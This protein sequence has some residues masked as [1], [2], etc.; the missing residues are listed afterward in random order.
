MSIQV[1]TYNLTRIVGGVSGEAVLPALNAPIDDIELALNSLSSRIGNM[2]NKSAIIRQYVPIAEGVTPGMLVYYDTELSRFAPA[3]AK[4]MA[5]PGS[6]GQSIEH[7]SSRVEG[8]IISIDSS[9]VTG[10]MLTGGA[11]ESAAVAQACLGSAAVAGTYYLSPTTAGKAVLDPGQHLRQAVLS[12]YGDG[13]LNLNMFYMAHDNHFHSSAVLTG[14]WLPVTAMED[15]SITIPTGATF[16]Y[17][18]V[19]DPNLA[20]VGELSDETTLVVHNGVIITPGTSFVISQGYLWSKELLIPASGEVTIFNHF[21]YAYNSPVVRSVTS[22]PGSSVTIKNKNGRVTIKPSD[23]ISGAVANSALAVSAISGNRILYTP[24][25]T[26]L[27]AGPGI[28]L[29]RATD[30]SVTVAASNLV[31]NPIDAYNV[32]HNGTLISSDGLFQYFTFPSG[33]SSELVM[34]LPVQDVA[35]GAEMQATVWGSC[36]GTGSSFNV[37]MYFVPQPLSSIPADMPTAPDKTSTLVISGASGKITYGETQHAIPFSGDGMLVA[38]VSIQSPPITDIK[39]LRMG[40]KLDIIS[41]PDVADSGAPIEGITAMIGSLASGYSSTK[42]DLV[43]VVSDRLSLCNSSNALTGNRCVGVAMDSVSV[44]Q[45]LT[46]VMAGIIQDVGFGFTAGKAVYVGLDGR[47]TQD[48][49]LANNPSV[50]YVQKIGM[51]LTPA[52]VQI[53]IE[54]A[55]MTEN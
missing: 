32:N 4:L 1:D 45:P 7:P 31:G 43:Y 38:V 24:V 42:Y 13:K 27:G 41:A 18:G 28:Q 3:I 25:V 12:Y 37:N 23:F 2:N 48:E 46:Y 35:A 14:T 50:K 17:N 11:Y 36:V 49:G 15:T 54:T 40:F 10:T 21:P 51:A 6:Q 5:Q 20:D 19:G 33:R 22:A 26:G 53:G 39:L 8:L 9:G 55:V 30:G 16:F 34:S 29:S 52:I 44:G 47:M